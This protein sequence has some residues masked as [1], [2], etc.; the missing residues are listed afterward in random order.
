MEWKM[1]SGVGD[2]TPS[3][4]LSLSND[5]VSLICEW[6]QR[7]RVDWSVDLLI[8]G[9]RSALSETAARSLTTTLLIRDLIEVSEAGVGLSADVTALFAA[10]DSTDDVVRMEVR[11]PVAHEHWAVVGLGEKS[12]IAN[13]GLGPAGIGVIPYDDDVAG[14]LTS[15]LRQDGPFELR[16]ERRAR[17][18]DGSTIVVVDCSPERGLSVEGHRESVD[19]ILGRLL[20]EKAVHPGAQPC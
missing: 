1:Q 6:L 5:E 16:A 13:R 7:E 12:L 18:G 8:A 4:W 10:L 9:G 15:L 3:P 20:G 14:F 19:S 11:T 17:D 2:N